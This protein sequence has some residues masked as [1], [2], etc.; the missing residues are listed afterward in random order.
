MKRDSTARAH[1]KTLVEVKKVLDRAGVRARAQARIAA[2]RRAQA[3]YA[4][5]QDPTGKTASFEP[6]ETQ[7]FGVE[8]ERLQDRARKQDKRQ[9]RGRTMAFWPDVGPPPAC[10]PGEIEIARGYLWKIRRA[11]DRGG[12]SH[13]E[14][15]YLWGLEKTWARRAS[16]EDGRFMIAGTKAGR[17]TV[18]DQARLAAWKGGQR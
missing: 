9:H 6:D 5:L 14:Y 1:A 15:V 10:G 13:S 18:G 4:A 8:L 11:L 16:G 12:W 7:M 17:L 2:R 3:R